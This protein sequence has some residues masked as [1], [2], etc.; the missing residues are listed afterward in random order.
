MFGGRLR[1]AG[2]HVV[3]FTGI[4]WLASAGKNV[5]RVVEMHDLLSGS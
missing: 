3:A 5:A 4:I 1:G 2:Q